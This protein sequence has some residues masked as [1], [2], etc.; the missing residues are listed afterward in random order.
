VN[1]GIF[2]LLNEGKVREEVN[3]KAGS[4]L[5]ADFRK[6]L[7]DNQFDRSPIVEKMHKRASR[8]HNF[9]TKFNVKTETL[10]Q[11]ETMSEN[12]MNTV[13]NLVPGGQG[14]AGEEVAGKTHNVFFYVVVAIL[15]IGAGAVVG[16]MLWGSPGKEHTVELMKSETDQGMKNVETNGEQTLVEVQGSGKEGAAAEL[17]EPSGSASVEIKPDGQSENP[18]VEADKPVILSVKS[19]QIMDLGR[20]LILGN[21]EKMSEIKKTKSL[22]LRDEVY[23]PV[24][25]INHRKLADVIPRTTG[26]QIKIK[27]GN[28][29]V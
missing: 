16:Y 29:I 19:H 2:E 10:S 27:K 17:A 23:E 26:V 6:L 21:K 9:P 11:H 4:R 15:L 8:P 3:E 18:A 28:R 22:K 7:S 12:G 20:T 24:Q 13:D 14:T 25:A 5:S 1:N